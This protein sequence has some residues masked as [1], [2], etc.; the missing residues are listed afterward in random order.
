M[1]IKL[2]IGGLVYLIAI[3]GP[4]LYLWLTDTTPT[5]LQGLGCMVVFFGGH[6]L[7]CTL[8]EQVTTAWNRA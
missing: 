5:T 6:I 4:G 1:E 3:F 2:L 7:S 8:I